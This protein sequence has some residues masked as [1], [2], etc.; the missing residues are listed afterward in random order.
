[1]SIATDFPM[2]VEKPDRIGRT[3]LLGLALWTGVGL[4]VFVCLKL[5]LP[6]H[7]PTAREAVE[8]KASVPIGDYDPA[9]AADPA[10][11]IVTSPSRCNPNNASK[12]SHQLLRAWL[13]GAELDGSPSQPSP[14][15]DAAL[16]SR[17]A[18]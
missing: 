15:V 16:R 1:M 2:F 6:Y 14:A 10:G 12:D 4:V 7:P 9:V 13:D 8:C 3:L 5:A 18:K 17:G 11:P